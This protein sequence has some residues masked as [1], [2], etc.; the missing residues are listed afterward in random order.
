MPAGF[1]PLQATFSGFSIGLGSSCLAHLIALLCPWLLSHA[2][3][4]E[5]RYF[6]LMVTNRTPDLKVLDSRR[7]P[8]ATEEATRVEEFRTARGLVN[9]VER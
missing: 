3:I 6:G 1:P 2:R 9:N 7:A 4:K 8:N 5:L